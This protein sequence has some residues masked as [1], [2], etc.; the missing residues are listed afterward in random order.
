MYSPISAFYPALVGREKGGVSSI[1]Y[2]I[3][4]LLMQGAGVEAGETEGNKAV[5]R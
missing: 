4:V 2:V 3:C 1:E 5:Q